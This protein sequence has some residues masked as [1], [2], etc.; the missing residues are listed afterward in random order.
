MACDDFDTFLVGKAKHRHNL[1]NTSTETS[2]QTRFGEEK[3]G[4]ALFGE[5]S[6]QCYLWK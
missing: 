4:Q 6:V 1:S 2:G 5:A 3:S